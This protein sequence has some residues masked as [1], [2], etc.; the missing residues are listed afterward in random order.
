MT[1][2]LRIS[3]WRR[4]IGGAVFGAQI[5]EIIEVVFRHADEAEVR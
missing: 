2:V 4:A 3:W 1:L 5:G